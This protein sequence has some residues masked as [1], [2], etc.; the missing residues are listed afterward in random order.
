MFDP[1]PELKN[2]NFEN[3][4][5]E[6]YMKSVVLAILCVLSFE[7]YAGDPF[8]DIDATMCTEEEDIYISCSMGANNSGAHD[9]PVASIC[10]KDN[11]SPRKGYVQYRYGIPPDAA[12][13][14]DMEMQCPTL[15]KPPMA[16]FAIYESHNYE[17][18]DGIDLALRFN[19]AGYV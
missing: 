9:G 3:I 11:S 7:L 16:R 15:A 13:G 14:L 17:G 4:M 12:S 5:A 18:G 6:G 19:S 1:A 10:A 2:R 8:V